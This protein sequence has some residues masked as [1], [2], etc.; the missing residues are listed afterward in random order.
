[1]DHPLGKDVCPDRRHHIQVPVSHAGPLQLVFYVPSEPVEG[2]PEEVLHQVPGELEPLVGVV[3]LV[4]LTA[5]GKRQLEAGLG[6]SGEEEGLGI[7]VLLL[8][9]YMGQKVAVQNICRPLLLVLLGLPCCHPGADLLQ[10][11]IHGGYLRLLQVLQHELDDLGIVGYAF[12]YIHIRFQPQ[13][14]QQGHEVDPSRDGGEGD[15]QNGPPAP[16]H[17][18]QRAIAL[19]LGEDL[20]HL[21]VLIVTLVVLH[22]DLVGSQVL[23]GHDHPLRAIDHEVAAGI[24]RILAVGYHLVGR[25]AVKIA[26]LGVEHYGQCAYIRLHQVLF[27]LTL[28]YGHLQLDGRGIGQ[29]AQPGIIG[30]EP[31]YGAVRLAHHGLFHP[32]L[33]Q[34]DICIL[35]I[36]LDYTDLINDLLQSLINK[37]IE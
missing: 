10:G 12:H 6:H 15:L 3:I 21:Y 23:Q 24:G 2:H 28:H 22:Q 17:N 13:G 34:L 14:S 27:R 31:L 35:D 29:I 16:L 26:D 20:G 7:T 11:L 19:P 30:V 33:A 32:D 37:I 1:M 18:D 8:H 4:V 9:S 5:L 36:G 25:E